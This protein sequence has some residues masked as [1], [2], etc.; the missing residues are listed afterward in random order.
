MRI[1]LAGESQGGMC[2]NFTPNMLAYVIE[3]LVSIQMLLYEQYC[4]RCNGV[5]VLNAKKRSS[6]KGN[7]GFRSSFGDTD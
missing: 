2:D 4:Y 7:D 5:N 1:D 6:K 3:I